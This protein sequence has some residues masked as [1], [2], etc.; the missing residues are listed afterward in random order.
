MSAALAPADPS[1]DRGTSIDAPPN[2]LL[3]DDTPANLQVLG[4]ML[5][6]Q[7]CIVRPAPSGRLAIRFAEADAPDIILLDIMMPEMDGYEVCR[8][9][10]RIEHLKDVPVIFISAL[11]ETLDKVKAF[12]A[13]GVDYI[14]KPFQCEEVQARLR[15]HLNIRRLQVR[16]ETQNQQLS[17]LN[18]ALRKSQDELD[19]E[20]V[21]AANYVLSLIP[22][23]VRKG[24]VQTNWLYIPST[25][26][27][28]D[29]LGYHWIDKQHFALYLL[30]VSGHGVAPALLSVSVLNTIRTQCLPEVDFRRPD[31]V[32]AALNLRFREKDQYGLSFSIWYGVFNC[33]NRML[34]YTNGGHPPALLLDAAHAPMDLEVGGLPI[35]FFAEGRYDAA[36]IQAQAGSRLYIFSDGCYEIQRRDGEVWT[37]VW[38][39]QDLVHYLTNVQPDDSQHLNAVY[40]QAVRA[41][42]GEHLDDDFSILCATF[43]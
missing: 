26:L 38:S 41:Q 29:A 16:L 4:G 27:G 17:Q 40:E 43:P 19:S 30:D 24:N 42:G 10:K 28:G 5:K 3:V 32:L 21:Y 7:G 25:R 22:P 37:D 13:G 6:E 11:N 33:S 8:R 18:D 20:L 12:A 14:S 34:H 1:D 9:M 31:E 39:R 35:G 36:A 2:V 23:P 15:T